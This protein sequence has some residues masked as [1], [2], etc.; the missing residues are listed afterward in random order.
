[1]KTLI[2]ILLILGFTT[3]SNFKKRTLSY[4]VIISKADLIVVGAISAV[5]FSVYEY[6][7]QISEFVKGTSAQK[8]TVTM[9]R[10][11]TCDRRIKFPKNGQ[12]LILFLSK[13]N[14]GNYE[15]INGSTGEL[16]ISE[17][18]TIETF[19]NTN[20]PNLKEF[21]TGI[22][23]FSKAYRFEGELYAR[24]SEKKYFKRLINQ[25]EIDKM[26]AESSFFKSMSSWIKA[27]ILE[28]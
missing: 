12:R 20:F 9:W 1:M 4:P 23:M 27:A 24:H 13:R 28:D 18:E 2:S 3:N 25:S 11:W 6:D 15:I 17:N 26:E 19:I 16:F 5:S 7:F 22:K 8:I 21:I 14:N 10:E